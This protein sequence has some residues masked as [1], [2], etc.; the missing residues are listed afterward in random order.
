MFNKLTISS[1]ATV[2]VLLGCSSSVND[3]VNN[4]IDTATTSVLNGNTK[5]IDIINKKKI[6]I[7][8]NVGRI[9]C[10]AIGKKLS[11][12]DYKNAITYIDVDTVSCNTYNKTKGLSTDLNATCIDQKFGKWQGENTSI[13]ESITTQNKDAINATSGNH[14]CVIGGDI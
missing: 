6:L 8:H 3:T 13:W 14:A 1:L 12:T 4:T 5:K 2:L 9:A 11:S 10:T 7:I